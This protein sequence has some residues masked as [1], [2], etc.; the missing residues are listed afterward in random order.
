MKS[1]ISFLMML[2]ITIGL[3]AQDNG[4]VKPI[5]LPGKGN[6]NVETLNKRINTKMDISNLS[7]CELRVLRN[8][9]AARQGYLFKSSEL[10]MVFNT[11]VTM[12]AIIAARGLLADR[13]AAFKPR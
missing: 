10:R 2:T 5:T 8:A 4:E 7:V 9:F 6:I 3:S 1:I 12:V 13:S 11:T